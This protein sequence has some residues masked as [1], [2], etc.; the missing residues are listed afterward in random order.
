MKRKNPIMF[1]LQLN[2]TGDCL[3]DGDRLSQ[4]V[5]VREFTLPPV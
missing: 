4:S 2:R 5:S 3:E 1:S